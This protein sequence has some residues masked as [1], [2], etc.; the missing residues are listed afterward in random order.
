MDVRPAGSQQTTC[1]Q[2][3]L[4]NS[5]VVA[6]RGW[7]KWFPLRCSRRDVLSEVRN[8]VSKR[9]DESREVFLGSRR[10]GSVNRRSDG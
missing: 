1:L 7:V 8:G 10:P 3:P 4:I 9:R 6:Q 2:M 5:P